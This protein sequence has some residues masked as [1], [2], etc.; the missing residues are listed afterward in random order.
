MPVPAFRGVAV[1]VIGLP[2]HEE[3]VPAMVTEGS[4][5]ITVIVIAELT[6]IVVVRQTA[7]LVSLQ[8]I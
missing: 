5:P 6:T 7:L 8:D 2:G 4:A 1:K 3:G